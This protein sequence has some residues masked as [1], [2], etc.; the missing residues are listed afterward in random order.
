MVNTLV[1]GNS[2]KT[3][4]ANS[5]QYCACYFGR[6]SSKQSANHSGKLL[7]VEA[8]MWSSLARRWL[9]RPV[10]RAASQFNSLL[11]KNLAFWILNDKSD[12]FKGSI[13][14]NPALNNATPWHIVNE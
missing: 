1:D 3:L 12:F 10:A 13:F 7:F 4:L 11:C 8:P 9:F 2:A 14:E 5:Y 6:I